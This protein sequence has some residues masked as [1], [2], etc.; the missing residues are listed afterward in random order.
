MVTFLSGMSFLSTARCRLYFDDTAEDDGRLASKP[1]VLFI[2][3]WALSG[4]YWTPLID[5]LMPNFRCITFDQSG[6]G[7]TEFLDAKPPFTISGFA[8]EAEALASSLGLGKTAPLHLVGHSMGSMVATELYHRLK[9]RVSSV[10][11]IACGIFDYSPTQMQLLETFVRAT[12]RL[13]WLFKFEPM[14]RAFVDKATAQ[15]IDPHY[16]KL[17]VEDFLRT[18]ADAAAA[19]GAFSLNKD[20]LAN[21][22]KQLLTIAAPMFLAVGDRDKTIPPEGM[23]TLFEKRS[24]LCDS[25]TRFVRFPML[26]HLPMLEDV[27][28]FA[29]E[30]RL[31][32]NAKSVAEYAPPDSLMPK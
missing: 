17:I 7:R 24:A 25:P 16:A 19:V 12:M 26:G 5:A 22:T 23:T 2:N 4:R 28:G 29:E 1:S 13:K 6:T 11:I 15:P 3:G 32:L 27:A 14:Q 10:T 20:I 31:F 8:D 21:Y 9:P 18:D 30:L